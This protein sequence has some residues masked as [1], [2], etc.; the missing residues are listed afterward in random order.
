VLNSVELKPVT[1][2]EIDELVW[3]SKETFFTAF[4]HLNRPADME[5]YAAQSFT[6]LK[7]QTELTTNGSSFYFAKVDG[8]TAG[9]MKLNTGN[10]QNEFCDQNSIELER[11]YISAAYQGKRLGEQLMQ[12][13]LDI[14]KQSG[15]QFIWLGVWE[16]NIRAIRF[17]ERMGFIQCGSHDFMLGSDRQTDLL[18]K[19]ELAS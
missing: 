16:H 19:L 15:H 11:L 12:F 3:L 14:A 2:A 18:M 17:Y 5:A 1:L 4:Y 10:A 8:K 6:R 7:L 9:F 13:A